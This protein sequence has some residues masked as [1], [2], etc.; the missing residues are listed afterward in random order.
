VR[1]HQVPATIVFSGEFINGDT[2]APFYWSNGVAA[3]RLRCHHVTTASKEA[4]MLVL[5]RGNKERI[6]FPSLGIS[7]EV[8]RVL[9]SRVRIGIEAPK[10]IPVHRGE[11]ADRIF[12]EGLRHGSP[13]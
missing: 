12:C 10:D 7:I 11:V 3:S 5:S 4:F 1:C 6:V 2:A 13:K 9:G 8:V